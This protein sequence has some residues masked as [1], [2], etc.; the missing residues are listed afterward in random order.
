MKSQRIVAK[1][2]NNKNL[3]LFAY[4]SI[5]VVEPITTWLPKLDVYVPMEY[6]DGVL[7]IALLKIFESSLLNIFCLKLC[8][9]YLQCVVMVTDLKGMSME[10]IFTLHMSTYMYFKLCTLLFICLFTLF[11]LC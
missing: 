4:I 10:T 8:G 1:D 5:T 11:L 9:Y 2:N 7:Y 6:S 3:F